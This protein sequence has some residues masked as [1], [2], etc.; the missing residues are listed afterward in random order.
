M[1]RGS[2]PGGGEIFRTCPDRPWSPSSFLY[3]GYRVFPGSKERP[4]RDADPSPPSSPVGH[5][6]IEL[7]LNS[8][9][10]V[11]RP[12]QGCT[13]P[14]FTFTHWNMYLY[15]ITSM[16]SVICTVTLFPRNEGCSCTRSW[17]RSVLVVVSQPCSR[18][19]S[20]LVVQLCV[21]WNCTVR[22]ECVNVRTC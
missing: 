1:V 20:Q 2:N 8:P 18:I 3:N 21:Y 15:H 12:V 16:D 4:G 22:V 10:W 11:V 9:L 13:L 6:R 5:E 19:I 14:F 7:Y 17:T